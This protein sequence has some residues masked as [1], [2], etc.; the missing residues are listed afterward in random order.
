MP[1]LEREQPLAVLAAAL[2]R[3][4]AGSGRMALVAGEVGIGKTTLIEHF[5]AAHRG[6]ARVLWG[7]CDALFTPRPLGPLR[8]IAAQAD[9]ALLGDLDQRDRHELFSMLL[10][11]LRERERPTIVVIEDV[12]WADEATLDLVKF[13]GRRMARVRALAIVT[14]RDDEVGA[15]H[16]LRSVLGD[17]PRDTTLRVRVE[18]LSAVAVDALVRASAHPSGLFEDWNPNVSCIRA[19]DASA[20]D[21]GRG[22]AHRAARLP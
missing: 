5:T 15:S 7:A 8:D 11:G 12:H 14:Y 3:V 9:D 18:P 16:P 2:D 19:A 22:V 4:E 6:R 17:L 21:A 10:R 13:L 1:L 20:P